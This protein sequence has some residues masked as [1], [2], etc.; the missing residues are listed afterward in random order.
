MSYSRFKLES[1]GGITPLERYDPSFVGGVPLA[2]VRHY[3]PDPFDCKSNTETDLYDDEG[4]TISD[5]I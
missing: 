3:S 1:I 2:S 5:I 4:N